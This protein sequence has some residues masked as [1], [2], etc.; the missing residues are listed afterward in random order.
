MIRRIFWNVKNSFF[1]AGML[2]LIPVQFMYFPVL[3]GIPTYAAT[4]LQSGM[5]D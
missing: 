2:V 1:G 3:M 5:I 4:V